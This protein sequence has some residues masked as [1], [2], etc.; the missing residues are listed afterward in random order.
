MIDNEPTDT[1]E[2]H[3]LTVFF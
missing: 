2:P 1:Q 3:S